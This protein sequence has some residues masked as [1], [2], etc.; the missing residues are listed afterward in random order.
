[1]R[2][3]ER[4]STVAEKRLKDWKEGQTVLGREG[5]K[6]REVNMERLSLQ[7]VSMCPSTAGPGCV[8]LLYL[9]GLLSSWKVE[10]PFI[11]EEEEGRCSGP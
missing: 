8:W 1:M 11:P 2:L 9:D 5:V 6:E 3:G 10:G 4:D 7:L